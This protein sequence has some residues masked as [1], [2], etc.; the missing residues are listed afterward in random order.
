MRVGG[1]HRRYAK[2][3]PR[4]LAREAVPPRVWVLG[5]KFFHNEPC[6]EV[7]RS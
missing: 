2:D 5:V 7:E 3:H 1:L 4:A 6:F